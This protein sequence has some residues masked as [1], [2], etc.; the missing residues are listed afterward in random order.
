MVV[1]MTVMVSAAVAMILMVTVVRFLFVF[2]QHVQLRVRRRA[3]RREADRDC[4]DVGSHRDAHFR[5]RLLGGRRCWRRRKRRRE[6]KP[7]NRDQE[8]RGQEWRKPF[9]HGTKPSIVKARP[10]DAVFA[11][12]SDCKTPWGRGV[13]RH[14]TNDDVRSTCELD[15]IPRTVAKPG[16][17][18]RRILFDVAGA[19]RCLF[20]RAARVEFPFLQKP[21][22]VS[23]YS[24]KFLFAKLFLPSPGMQAGP[25]PFGQCTLQSGIPR[26]SQ[27]NRILGQR[28]N[29]RRLVKSIRSTWLPDHECDRANARSVPL[30]HGSTL[31]R[32][33]NPPSRN[34]RRA[35]CSRHVPA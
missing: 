24:K 8:Q 27:P 5:H 30:R 10:L 11:S 34:G 15:H 31:T 4:V 13:R 29:W 6:H 26:S 21:Q 23:F 25:C 7:T 35:I 18:T 20:G 3:A 33:H 2:D 32:F 1:A 16:A 12:R 19:D 28:L 17:R 9:H 22:I 14:L